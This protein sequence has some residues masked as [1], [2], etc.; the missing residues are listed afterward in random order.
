MHQNNFQIK[1]A[2]IPERKKSNDEL[3]LPEISKTLSIVAFF[4]MYGTLVKEFIGKGQL[5][6]DLNL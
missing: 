4:E 2:T 5:S 6:F 3:S 1:Y